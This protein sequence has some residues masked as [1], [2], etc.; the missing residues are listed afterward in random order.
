MSDHNHNQ[1]LT[2]ICAGFPDIP[3]FPLSLEVDQLQ[4]A[5]PYD[6]VNISLNV[7]VHL[8]VFRPDLK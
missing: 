2:K 3:G 7:F 4:E 5:I 1:N 8:A 6:L